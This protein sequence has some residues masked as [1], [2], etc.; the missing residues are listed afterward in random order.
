[1]NPTT[2]LGATLSTTLA[3]GT[4]YVCVEGI[5]TGSP[6][7]GYS[8]YGSLGQFALTGTLVP[9]GNQAPVT[10][11]NLSAPLSGP[12]P[13]TVNF[14][15]SGSYDPDGTI[16]SYSWDFGDGGTSILAN[17]S[18]SYSTAGTYIASLIVKTAA[19]IATP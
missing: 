6:T 5:G 11:A 9:V 14:S 19:S 8:N 10:A 12:A 15:S 7:L 17:P 3:Q 4:Y 1:M 2:T 16:P 13:L 18:H